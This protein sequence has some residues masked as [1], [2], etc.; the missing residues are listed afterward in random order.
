MR[1]S[2]GE[3]GGRRL[4]ARRGEVCEAEQIGLTALYNQMDEGAWADLKA[5]HRELHE[6][7]AVAYGWPTNIAQDANE[8]NRRLLELN[9]EIAE[10]RRLYDPFAYTTPKERPTSS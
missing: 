4:I 2:I 1:A 7:V 3:I 5:L 9:R 10:G 6:A 8:T